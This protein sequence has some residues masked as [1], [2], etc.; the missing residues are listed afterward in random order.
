MTENRARW[1]RSDDDGL[2]LVSGFVS[3]RRRA[4]VRLREGETGEKA[5]D[6]VA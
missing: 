1:K 3:L 2:S 6:L 5:K 4:L